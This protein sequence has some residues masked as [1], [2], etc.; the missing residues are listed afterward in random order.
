MIS[1]TLSINI[2]ESASDYKINIGQDLLKNCGEWARKCLGETAKKIIVVSNAK[3]FRLYGEK[4]VNS[5]KKQGFD[6][7]VFLMKDGEK[8]K[9]FRVLEKLLQFFSENKLTRSDAAIA[10]GG[11]VVG[12]LTGFAAAIYLRGIPFLQIPTTLLAMIDSSVG[13]KTAVNSSFGKNLIGA[14]YQPKGVLVDSQTLQT[15]QTRELTAGF[16]EAVKQG[17]ISS[18]KLFNQTADFLRKYPTSKFKKYYFNNNF[19]ENLENLIAAQIAFKAEIV[20]ADE[21][22]NIGRTDIKSRKI[23]NFGHTVGHALEKVT[24]Y[25]YFKHGEAVGYGI[26]CAAE[27]SKNIG[28]FDKDTLNLLDDVV[29]LTGNLPAT[30]KIE[31]KKLT[32]A[33][34][35][36]K[37]LSGNNLQWILLEKIGSPVIFNGKEIPATLLIKSLR[38]VL[39]K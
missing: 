3:I 13:G 2:S 22:E 33:F 16:C 34:E 6:V 14:F 37:K 27:I 39:T 8:Y 4:T 19:V 21:R 5:L 20:A 38:T 18:E 30:D 11:G 31:I 29:A 12:D 23:L 10:L 1:K 35:F 28:I 32:E 15:L 7:F 17:A 36:D 26:L 24:G 25:K 9:N